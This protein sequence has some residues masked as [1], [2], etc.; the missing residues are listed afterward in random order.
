MSCIRALVKGGIWW[1][2]EGRL[3]SRNVLPRVCRPLR[4]CE[5][6]LD[7]DP[8][9]NVIEARMEAMEAC[10]KGSSSQEQARNFVRASITDEYYDHPELFFAGAQ[11][12]VE[13]SREVALITRPVVYAAIMLAAHRQGSARAK[14]VAWLGALLMDY[15]ASWPEVNAALTKTAPAGHDDLSEYEVEE[16]ESRL[17]RLLLYLV[18]EP[19]YTSTTKSI[20]D[21]L[22]DKAGGWRLLAPLVSSAKAY[23]SL[24]EES[25]LYVSGS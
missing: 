6:S 1:L 7:D 24:C 2:S 25:Q 21:G 11:G 4:R 17:L 5:V 13:K 8:P 3:V 16:R 9:L 18:R 12:F 10:T 23:L 19:F 14:S 22:L 15:Y 20:L